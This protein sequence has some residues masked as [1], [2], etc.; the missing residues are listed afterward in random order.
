MVV[1]QL[2]LNV[3]PVSPL[4]VH[5]GE[6]SKDWYVGVLTVGAAGATRSSVYVVLEMTGALR[7]PARS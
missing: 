1:V 7:L 2:Q 3:A 6:V 5:T 4:I